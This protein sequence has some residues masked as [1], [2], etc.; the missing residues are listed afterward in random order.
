M[1]QFR[2]RGRKIV[3]GYG[4]GKALVSLTPISFYG[5]INPESGVVVERGHELE[6]ELVSHRILVF[7]TGKGSTV[8]S[9][10]IYQMEK[11]KTAPAGIIMRET[12]IIV[13]TGCAMAGIP[14]VDRL[15]ADPLKSI[16]TGDHIRLYGDEAYVE[17][18]RD[19]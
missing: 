5:G 16:E 10:T 12:E 18:E 13:A 9:Y 3:G 1:T 8:G 15:E 2:Y 14:L 17:I 7:P 11:L 4:E 6:G 19:S